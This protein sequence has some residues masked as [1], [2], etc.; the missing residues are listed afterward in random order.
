[1]WMQWVS[2]TFTGVQHAKY[3]NELKS[4]TQMSAVTVL[5]YFAKNYAFIP[6]VIKWNNDQESLHPFGMYFR[7]SSVDEMSH[8]GLTTTV[9][10][11]ATTN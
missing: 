7:K 8:T 5:H 4:D 1:M 2:Y 10:I 3:L 9:A 11:A 6:Q